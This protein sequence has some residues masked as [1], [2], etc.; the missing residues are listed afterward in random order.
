MTSIFSYLNLATTSFYS[1]EHEA[2]IQ[3]DDSDLSIDWGIS[4]S[5]VTLSEKDQ[6]LPSFKHLIS[7]FIYEHTL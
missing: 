3:F 4:T 6:D 2:G 1:P 7:P 5:E